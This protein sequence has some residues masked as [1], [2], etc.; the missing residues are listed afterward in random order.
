MTRQSPTLETEKKLPKQWP[1]VGDHGY[2]KFLTS[3]DHKLQDVERLNGEPMSDKDKNGILEQAV[4]MSNALLGHLNWIQMNSLAGSISVP[5]GPVK[6]ID[7]LPTHTTM[8]LSFA[9]VYAQLLTY[10][11]SLDKQADMQQ[12]STPNRAAN[13]SKCDGGDND[14]S[15]NASSG[16]N[17]QGR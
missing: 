16:N 15:R 6:S 13:E 11:I 12:K 9:M 4:V 1:P 3:W 7:D 17:I 14:N 8:M 5:L 10:A 2:E